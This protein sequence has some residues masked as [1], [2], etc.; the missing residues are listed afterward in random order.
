L[1]LTVR[2]EEQLLP[3]TFEFALDY[4][5]DQLDLSSF[6]AAFRNDRNGAPG[7]LLKSILSCYS[8]G[9]ITS[10]PI[11][12]ACKTNSIVKA[13]ARDAEP[14]HDPIAH[15]ISSQ[16]QAVTELCSHVLFEGHARGLIG[17]ELFALDRCKLPSNASKEWSGTRAELSKQ[18]ED[19]KQVME[20]IVE[21]HI[22]LD[23]AGKAQSGLNPTAVAYGYDQEYRERLEKLKETMQHLTGAAKPLERALGE[24]DSGYCSENKLRAAKQRGVD[25]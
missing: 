19:C 2:L 6:D 7:L 4:L 21:Q 14:D 15:F 22:P 3:G 1:F 10:R 11:E 23:K 18:Q 24:G 16:G 17:G 5:I 9:I 12:Q 25:V 20:T 8:R 13:L